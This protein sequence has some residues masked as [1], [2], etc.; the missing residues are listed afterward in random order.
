M[1]QYANVPISKWGYSRDA[2]ALY[3][4]LARKFFLAFCFPEC[5]AYI[6]TV[7]T[8]KKEVP[9]DWSKALQ[10][11]IKKYKGYK[12]PLDY[13]NTYQLL[14]M[15]ILSA[16]DSDERINEIA[17]PLFK[18]FPTLKSL[19][20]V[21]PEAL[22]PYVKKVR[23]YVKKSEWII[24]IASALK[25]DKNIPLTMEGL[26]AL[27]G[28]G[29]KSANVILRESGAPAEGIMVDLHVIRV[30]L[31]LGITAA[32]DPKK[33]ELEMMSKL[34]PKDWGEAGMAISFLG[35]ETCRPTNPKH[36]ECV[37]KAVCEYC[38][39]HAKG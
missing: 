1:C 17:P 29:R 36:N 30:A 18:A 10:P 37:M 35:R 38:H 34:L 9:A 39:E 33:I 31:R 5:G 7:A 26:V 14:V 27:Q 20:N 6:H 28:I 19:A 2:Q 4:I 25:T 32:S 11:L 16:R 24:A 23:S 12:H 3:L 13:K 8:T 15:V 22:Y 21:S